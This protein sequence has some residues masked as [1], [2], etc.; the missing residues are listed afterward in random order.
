MNYKQALI[1]N[2]SIHYMTAVGIA[3]LSAGAAGTSLH[4]NGDQQFRNTN[5]A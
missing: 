1:M 5:Y 3:M 4:Q 2:K